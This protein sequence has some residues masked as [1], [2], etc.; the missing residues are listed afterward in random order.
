MV[1]TKAGPEK[2]LVLFLEIATEKT[3]RSSPA[4][5]GKNRAGKSERRKKKKA[6]VGRKATPS[7]KHLYLRCFQS[8]C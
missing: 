2:R 4:G 5:K 7:V 3:P 1:T 8:Q 6:A